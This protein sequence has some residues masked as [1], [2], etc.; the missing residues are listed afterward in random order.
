MSPVIFA[1]GGSS[2]DAG[3]NIVPSDKKS[4]LSHKGELV[5]LVHGFG[6]NSPRY[7]DAENIF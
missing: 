7:A 6:E 1:F 3:I 4:P 5:V 2:F